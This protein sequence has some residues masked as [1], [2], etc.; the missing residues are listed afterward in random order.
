MSKWE[1]QTFSTPR[2]KRV[3]PKV[4]S[5]RSNCQKKKRRKRPTN[6][7]PSVLLV[8]KLVRPTCDLPCSGPAWPPMLFLQ[9]LALPRK[10]PR[11]A[12][13]PQVKRIAGVAGRTARAAARV[14]LPALTRYPRIQNPMPLVE[15]RNVS[16]IYQLG[17]EIG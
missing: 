9:P 1:S 16:K 15:L 3:S 8:E 5:L 13:V 2:F 14:E 4:T 11:R 17:E 7:R 12:K 6:S 10:Q